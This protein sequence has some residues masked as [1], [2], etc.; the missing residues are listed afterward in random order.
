MFHELVSV[1]CKPRGQ[2]AC[3]LDPEQ[4]MDGHECV[5]E[6]MCIIARTCLSLPTH[7]ASSSIAWLLIAGD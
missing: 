4:S 5:F 3:C 2:D 6:N 7:W 1:E